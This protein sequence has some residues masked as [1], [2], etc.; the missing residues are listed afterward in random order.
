[1][2]HFM[3]E[4]LDVMDSMLKNEKNVNTHDMIESTYKTFYDEYKDSY[5]ENEWQVIRDN[6]HLF[7]SILQE[8]I[9]YKTVQ[10]E[11]IC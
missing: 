5:T 3:E 7:Y 8:I 4:L 6:T 1:M 2:D 11:P 9:D 10:N